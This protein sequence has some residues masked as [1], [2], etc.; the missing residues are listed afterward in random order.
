MGFHGAAVAVWLWWRR[1]AGFSEG[2]WA[3]R[4][5]KCV[6]RPIDAG[7]FFFCNFAFSLIFIFFFLVRGQFRAR[8]KFFTRQQK[9]R[10]KKEKK[11]G[12]PERPER[13]RPRPRPGPTALLATMVSVRRR[14]MNRSGVAKN[15]RRNN[16][17]DKFNP[18]SNPVIAKHWDPELTAKQNYKKLGLAFRLSA[19]SG[20]EEKRL[21]VRPIQHGNMEESLYEEE[22]EAEE[23]AEEELDPYAPANILEGTAKM[24]R[25]ADGNVVKIVY[26]TKKIVKRDDAEDADESADDDDDDDDSTAKQVIG[27]L[28]ELARVPK[29][30]EVR[31]MNELETARC[32]R[33]LAAYGDDYERMRWD[34]KLN[35]F[36]LSPGQLRKLLLRFRQQEARD[37]L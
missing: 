28:E 15:T 29:R 35:P 10:D 19:A 31:R 5:E 8:D 3:D 16:N 6:L 18:R 11:R 27:E 32:R 25:D 36:Q 4:R 9:K 30:K 17:K 37:G 14:K 22:E 21:G 13:P 20:G 12:R 1:R 34:G 7:Q 2:G 33:L 23:E 24:V 26:G